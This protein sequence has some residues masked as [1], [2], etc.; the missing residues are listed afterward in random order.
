VD[1]FTAAYLANLLA[2]LSA[3][4]IEQIAPRFAQWQPDPM[5]PALERCLQLGVMGI[6][7]RASLDEPERETLLADIFERFFSQ[8]DVAKELASLARGQSLDL[9]E[10]EYLFKQAGYDAETLPGLQFPEAITAFEAAFREAAA[11]EPALHPLIPTEPDWAQTEMQQALV[12]EMRQMIQEVA[13]R[14]VSRLTITGGRIVMAP[15]GGV[16][17]DK[18]K[19]VNVVSGAQTIH[20]QTI[21]YQLSGQTAPLLA[22]NW[23][24]DYLKAVAAHCGGLDLTLLDAGEARQG[25]L[26]IAAVFTALYLEGEGRLA[27]EPLTDRLRPPAAKRRDEPQPDKGKERQGRP[28][29][30]E[31]ERLPIAATEAVAALPRL[32]ILG[33][34]GGGKSTLVRHIATQLAQRRQGQAAAIPACPDDYAP[35]P[36]V[37]TLRHFDK[38]LTQT[39]REGV[40]GDLW[41]YLEQ[42]LLPSWGCPPHVFHY[43]SGA[44]RSQPAVLFFDGLDEISQ[45]ET[46]R[47]II[48][49]VVEKFA[50]MEPQCQVVV[51]SRPYAY[52]GSAEWRLPDDQFV[53][54]SLAPFAAQQIEDFNQAWYDEVIRLRRN[55][56]GE[57]CQREADQLSRTILNRPH[58]YRLAQSPLLL[59][60]IAQVHSYDSHSTLPN[61]RAALYEK[62]VDLLL[63]R[64]EKRLDEETSPG[65]PGEEL[66]GLDVPLEEMRNLLAEL[67]Y[68]GHER[69]GVDGQKTDPDASAEISYRDLRAALAE[70]FEKTPKQVDPI[71]LYIE[72]RAGL[73]RDKGN[74][75]FDFPH[76][77][78]QEY[79]AARHLLNQSDGL[80]RLCQKVKERP[81]WWREVFLLCAG[82]GIGVPKTVQDLINAALPFGSTEE[83]TKLTADLAELALIAAQAL[84]E[85]NFQTHVKQEKTPGGFTAVY[86]RVQGWLKTIMAAD[87]L[88][89]AAKRAEAGRRLAELG[90]DRPGVGVIVR[91]GRKL[92]DIAWSE[93]I[94]P[95]SL[96]LPQTYTIGE[97]QDDYDDEKP[98]P[99]L[100]AQPFRIARYPI[101]N[102]QFQCFLEAADR[103]DGKWWRGL[104]EE[105]KQFSEPE[106]AYANQPREMVSWYQA[107]AFCRWLTHRLHEGALPNIPLPSGELEKWA[108]ALPHEYEWEVAARWPNGDAQERIYPWGSDIDVNKAN[109]EEGSIGQTTAVGIYPSGR[110]KA[111]DLYDLS[112]NVWEWCRNKYDNPDDDKVDSSGHRR[113]LRGASWVGGQY[114]ARAAYRTSPLPGARR[115][116]RGFRVVV[117]RRSPSHP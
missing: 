74:G 63:A 21:I 9:F 80:E 112:G 114:G 10:L 93:Q 113:V 85:T 67:A 36:V 20:N 108:I 50:E 32:V 57:E 25:R 111:L 34:P 51:T 116:S 19:A 31:K 98:R 94:P 47:E 49:G 60:L 16:Q 83:G 101:T 43:L 100:I 39:G 71:I 23:E 103:E 107:T 14:D 2:N 54:V 109:T 68:D 26:T 72:R 33:R 115:R 3:R 30:E 55:W 79:L 106:W 65:K 75:V 104:P 84:W 42:K 117:V 89:P 46:R 8:A 45:I 90:D 97:D 69:Q 61:N 7:A 70:R 95:A 105:E 6:V 24:A 13:G 58:L 82:S 99:A 35:L 110:N 73:L 59:T 56:S 53:V 11:L 78:Y 44:L 4:L 62:M 96:K 52:E 5:K 37:V 40:V 88:L 64:W 92:P 17:A 1:G 66:P 91:D 27:D 76:R 77:T 38:W 12:A 81:D 15:A 22:A 48:R 28:Q 41:A 102:V 86:R 87:A 18:I 29:L